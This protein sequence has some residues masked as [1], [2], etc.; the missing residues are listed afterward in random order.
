MLS[1]NAFDLVYED[2]VL[3]VFNKPSGLL[4]VPGKGPEKA[5]CLRTRV[6]QVYPEALTVHRL[7]MS[8]SGL[9]LMAR[10]A[11]IHR[12]LSIA[13]ANR[14]VHKRYVAVVNA[15]VTN[16][17]ADTNAEDASSW[18]LIDLPIATD[19]V[20][21]PLMKIDKLEGKSSQ[22]HYRVIKYDAAND[23]THLE[24]APVTGRTHQLRLHLQAIGHSILG[25]HLYA[26]AEVQAK[27]TRLMLH[28]SRL[29]LKHPVTGMPMD[30]CLSNPF[31]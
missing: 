4:S 21:R 25:D 17:A 18:R 28:A 11:E 19:W 14:D 3:L 12:T 31:N 23:C 2:D 13:F 16:D 24:L 1:L 7:D 10:N 29:S 15:C 5:D 8:T 30:W 27:S 6:Q 20:N 26:T 22:T 9:L